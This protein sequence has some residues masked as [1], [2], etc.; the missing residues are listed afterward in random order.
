MGYAISSS[1]RVEH[2]YMVDHNGIIF[3]GFPDQ[4]DQEMAFIDL[5][6]VHYHPELSHYEKG[7]SIGHLLSQMKIKRDPKA[8]FDCF[9]CPERH[10][11]IVNKKMNMHK[12]TKFNKTT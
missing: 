2:R 5:P 3:S 11:V 6:I 7:I 9:L 12:S 10:S 4:L 1:L 8:E